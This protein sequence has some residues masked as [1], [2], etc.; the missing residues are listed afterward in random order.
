MK[1][2]TRTLRLSFVIML[3]LL[4]ARLGADAAIPAHAAPPTQIGAASAP[5]SQIV[6]R[7]LPTNSFTAV[8][9]PPGFRTGIRV[10]TATISVT[11]VGF[12][13]N[14]QAQAA[15]AAFQ[16]AV[17][18]WETLI[19][20][21]VPIHVTATWTPLGDGILGSAGPTHVFRD[22]PNAPVP[23][24]WY[25]VALANKLAGS[26][27]APSTGDIS[28]WFN[29][30]FGS[31][32][33]FGTDE[34]TEPGKYSFVSVVLH[35][36]GHG[37]G[38]VGSMSVTSSMANR[39][40]LQLLGSWGCGSGLPCIY[41]RFAENGAGQSLVN[42]ALF[43]NHSTAL[44]TQL[45]SQNV[46]FDGPA[47]SAANGGNRPK[48]YAPNPFEGGSSFSH[49]DE[50]TFPAGNL[51]SLM[52]PFIG[53]AET[54]HNPGPV[55]LGIFQDLGWTAGSPPPPSNFLLNVSK[56]G[57]GTVT[58]TS[59]PSP[60]ISCGATCSQNYPGGAVVTLTATPAAGWQFSGWSGACGGTGT[61]VVTMDASKS[62]TATFTLSPCIRDC[63]PP[64]SFTLTVTKAGSGTGAVAS[65]APPSPSIS[66]GGACAATY[67][68]GTMV[69]LA[70]VADAGSQFTGWGGACGG[71]GNCVVTMDAAK[72]V[73]ATFTLINPPQVFTLTVTKN[74]Q[75]TVASTSPLSPSINCGGACAATYPSGTV[76]TLAATPSAGWI[77][78]GWGGACAGLG[79]C[80]VTM[81]AAKGVTATF[82]LRRS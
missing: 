73:T 60:A 75:G 65:T 30:D 55:T 10:Q 38:F 74:G 39:G 34:E 49:L 81:D 70:A 72:A 76:V 67:P 77:F 44:A 1:P 56:N 53:A 79:N 78:V 57:Q 33:D 51:N 32:W 35:E 31:N 82:V 45:T 37:L 36:L 47:V 5:G 28:A 17:D 27:L 26:D 24:T 8:A 58:S 20:S 61:C 62:V 13:Q 7:A 4:S 43:P 6:L 29:S 52:T 40:G 64:A 15:Q 23:N 11:Y 59:P 22:F 9:P 71:T 48:L 19:T 66:C 14:P 41:D 2:A 18:I 25:P 80:T 3:I 42:S 50:A 68:S 46:F 16:Y 12:D 54:I 21:S 69:T 63:L